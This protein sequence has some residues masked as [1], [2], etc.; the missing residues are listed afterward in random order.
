MEQILFQIYRY[1]TYKL[2][3]KSVY[4]IHSPFV[5]LFYYNVVVRKESKNVSNT[6]KKSLLYRHIH[7]YYDRFTIIDFS[8]ERSAQNYR[9]I[10]DNNNTILLF[11]DLNKDFR[12]F[13]YWKTFLSQRQNLIFLDFYYLGVVI[14]NDSIKGQYHLTCKI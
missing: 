14:H 3:A 1:I 6:S 11:K 2:R 9:Q 8:T 4:H 7:D 10:T 12:T 5:F 13:H